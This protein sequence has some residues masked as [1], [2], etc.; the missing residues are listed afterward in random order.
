M[1]PWRVVLSAP[2]THDLRRLDRQ[3][4]GRITAAIQRL[5]DENL[6]DVKKLKG[7]ENRWRLRV[8]DW[9]VIF[10]RDTQ[11]REIV[12]LEVGSRGGAYRD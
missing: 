8:G 1:S 2:A 9:R 3:V 10:A 6:G 7:R 4:S 5:A 11:A 12:V